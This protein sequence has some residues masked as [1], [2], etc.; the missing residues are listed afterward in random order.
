MFLLVRVLSLLCT[1]YIWVLVARMIFSWI[2]VLSPGFRPRG[3]VAVVFEGV[4]TIT[5]PPI[6]AV[7]RVVK[8][9]RLGSIGLDVA[10]M[11]VFLA[12]LVIQRLIWFLV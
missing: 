7:R 5:D 3:V 1:L 2:P 4:Y 12:V 9:I 8:P 11:V 10:F 6:N